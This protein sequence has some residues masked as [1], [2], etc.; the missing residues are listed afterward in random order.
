MNKKMYIGDSVYV[1]YDGYNI[2]LSTKGLGHDH[3]CA[4]ALEPS[5]LEALDLFRESVLPKC[6]KQQC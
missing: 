5:V 2:I 6:D 4:I 1:E 3:T